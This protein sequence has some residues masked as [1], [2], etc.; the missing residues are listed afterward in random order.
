MRQHRVRVQAPLRR[1]QQHIGDRDQRRVPGQPRRPRHRPLPRLRQLLK[2]SGH[3]RD[4]QRGKQHRGLMAHI[5]ASGTEQMQALPER[6]LCRAVV[7]H[8]GLGSRPQ[9]G[10]TIGGIRRR[11]LG[12]QRHLGW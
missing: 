1:G 2:L 10:H 7:R 4:V 5:H 8:P 9:P 6:V 11:G 12:P 3:Q